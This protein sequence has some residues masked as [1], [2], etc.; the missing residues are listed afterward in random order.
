MH[1]IGGV[2][3]GEDR[4]MGGEQ[5]LY[6]KCSLDARKEYVLSNFTEDAKSKS[7]LKTVGS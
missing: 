2:K 4:F 6:C 5:L 3:P 1:N 7:L